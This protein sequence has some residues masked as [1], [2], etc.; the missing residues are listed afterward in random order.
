MESAFSGNQPILQDSLRTTRKKHVATG[1]G[2]LSCKMGTPFLRADE[3]RWHARM[4]A[5]IAAYQRQ[6]QIPPTSATPNVV[7]TLRN[8]GWDG[9]TVL[10]FTEVD[11]IF[12]ASRVAECVANLVTADAG[13]TMASNN[14]IA[15]IQRETSTFGFMA[16]WKDLRNDSAQS[17]ALRFPD[18]GKAILEWASNVGR[19]F[20]QSYHIEQECQRLNKLAYDRNSGKEEADAQAQETLPPT[21]Q[22]PMSGLAPSPFPVGVC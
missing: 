19:M 14:L 12:V 1:K 2:G 6:M 3:E 15:V 11:P 20:A 7:I 4:L 22:T 10:Q 13:I 18:D 17:V 5:G 9:Q 8:G 21:P 16:M